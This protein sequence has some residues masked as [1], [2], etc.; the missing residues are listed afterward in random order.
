MSNVE[1][2]RQQQE[3]SFEPLLPPSRSRVPRRLETTFHRSLYLGA[4]LMRGRPIG[5]LMGRLRDWDKLDAD[6]YARLSR[7]RLDQMLSF[8]AA[9]VP[10][11][12]SSPWWDALDGHAEDI[13]RWPVLER[14]LLVDRASTLVPD[15]MP[16]RLLFPRRSSASTG[17]PVEVLWTLEAVAWSWA[18]EYHPM[19]WH[20]LVIGARTLRMWGSAHGFE[21]FVLNRHFVP[22]H[23]LTPERLEAAVRYLETRSP[24]LV[25][26][27]PSAVHEL[28]RHI[29][30]TR[31]PSPR[32]RVP[33]VK[34]GGEQLYEF[35]R[36]DIV[37]HLNGRVIESYGSTEMGPIAAECPAGALH[38]LTAN[39]HIEIFRDGS[40]AR[41]GEHGEVIATTLV[42]RG[43][44]LVRCRIG[45]L[46]ALSPEPCTC[47]RPQPVLIGL[48]GRAADLVQ[49]TDGTPIH[50]SALGRALQTFAN[51]PPLG[52]VQ[53]IR[54]EQQDRRTWKVKI[55][56][57]QP[58]DLETLERQVSDLMRDVL[59][60]DC[61]A[62]TEIV[63]K[64]ERE[65]SGKY[66][67][68]RTLQGPRSA[69]PDPDAVHGPS[70]G[71]QRA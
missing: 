60:A 42:N 14:R 16:T 48:Q 3:P 70:A 7:S 6:A 52:A 38:V 57:H 63:E 17:T 37:R 68:Y 32:A 23:D 51:Q 47:G 40:P 11:Y 65:P 21:N 5:K 55:E 20:A 31:M 64:I 28:A 34:V 25:W 54:F 29:S 26:G 27:T 56:S 30:R 49:K 18:A 36:D 33:Y 43:M 2:A 67:Y 19:G 71:A 22:A 45:D 46:A 59:G 15:G 61:R 69:G 35:Q 4:Q 50:G 53:K 62:Q 12:R 44:P 24:E 8:A 1:F 9:R 13:H 10:L 41:P 66:R 39:V 58:A